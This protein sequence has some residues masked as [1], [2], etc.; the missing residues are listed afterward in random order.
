MLKPTTS[1]SWVMGCSA[2]VT[3]APVTFPRRGMPIL[4]GEPVDPTVLQELSQQQQRPAAFQEPVIGQQLPGGVGAVLARPND[5][6]IVGEH[7]VGDDSAA[8]QLIHDVAAF[9]QVVRELLALVRCGGVGERCPPAGTTTHR[10]RG[11]HR[12]GYALRGSLVGS[13]PSPAV[14]RSDRVPALVRHLKA[15]RSRRPAP[16]LR[17][18]SGIAGRP[19]LRT[20][21]ERVNDALDR[22]SEGCGR[23]LKADS[24]AYRGMMRRG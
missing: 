20:L 3:I 11:T 5:S 4:L 24:S 1:T 13:I 14:R 2:K 7:R 6:F 10:R 16:L 18:P 15:K 21:R 23:C 19:S 12:Q 17:G 9:P 22:P 8:R